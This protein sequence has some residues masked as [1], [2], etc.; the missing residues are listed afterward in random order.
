MVN[1][2]CVSI[3]HTLLPTQISF[4]HFYSFLVRFV[5]FY[6]IL[7]GVKS[8]IIMCFGKA[9]FLDECVSVYL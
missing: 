7:H 3:L 1:S 5:L 6:F 4:S 2:L 8:Q 9:V